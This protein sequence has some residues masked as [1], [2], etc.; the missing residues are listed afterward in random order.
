MDVIKRR[1]I[2]FRE[3]LSLLQ[4]FP[5]PQ[6][7]KPNFSLILN[8]GRLGDTTPLSEGLNL[9]KNIFNE[10]E[11]FWGVGITKKTFFIIRK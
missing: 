2:Y 5:D 6:L 7:K 8:G 11:P 4:P 1:I 10:L 3:R 9:E